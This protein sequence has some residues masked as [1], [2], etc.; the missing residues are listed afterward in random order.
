MTAPRRRALVVRGGWPGHAPEET[1]D[2]VVPVLRD[3]G[4]SVEIAD[5]LD[6][7]LDAARLQDLSVIVQCWTLG[8]MSAEH[9]AG[10]TGAVASGVGF[11]GWHGG[12][13]DAFRSRPEYL[14]MVGGQFVAHPGGHVD[15]RIELVPERADHPIVAGLP[16][17]FAVHTEQYWVLA[18]D[19]N[20]VLATTTIAPGEQ[21]D[22]P[23]TCPAVWTRN[24][25]H[26]R[27]FVCTLGHSPEDL[28]HPV[29]RAVVQ[30]GLRWAAR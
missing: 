13:V 3:A 10:L 5:D 15:H 2:L 18:D 11:G 24:W 7:Y 19:Y 20:D 16:S 27:V 1:T 17:S 6:V 25:G 4:H 23:V 12:V 22:R 28:D 8:R 14:Q 9:C 30:R 29:T 26:G 21:W